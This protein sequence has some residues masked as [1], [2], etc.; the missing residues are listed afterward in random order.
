MSRSRTLLM[1]LI[2]S[3]TNIAFAQDLE[4]DQKALNVIT[5]FAKDYCDTVPLKSTTES[6]EVSGKVKAGITGLVKKLADLGI[7]GAAVYR[8]TESQGVLQKDLAGLAKDA[9]DCRKMIWQDLRG[10]FFPAVKDKRTEADITKDKIERTI[11]L[12]SQ[13]SEFQNNSYQLYLA[14]KQAKTT[15]ELQKRDV[16][17]LKVKDFYEDLQTGLSVGLYDGGTSK[18]FFCRNSHY[19]AY[20][21][22][23]AHETSFRQGLYA[24]T[25]DS[26]FR[27]AKSCPDFED[28]MKGN[29]DWLQWYDAKIKGGKI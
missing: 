21:L 27:F 3:S 20:F 19:H 24:P 2:A 14:A 6:V 10:R 25:M 17:I 23:R 22:W 1:F 5:A 4:K 29:A 18:K 9:K 16:D 8:T 15:M 12:K 13:Y 11:S 28:E 26:V 7:E